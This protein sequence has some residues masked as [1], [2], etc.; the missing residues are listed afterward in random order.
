MVVYMYEHVC[1]GMYAC[2]YVCIYVDFVFF[3]TKKWM[4]DPLLCVH[5]FTC[6]P[7]L[8]SAMDQAGPCILV[9]LSFS[10]CLQNE[11]II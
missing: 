1:G 8:F 11:L 3:L 6:N 2:E 4:M 10:F 5:T 7:F 9:S